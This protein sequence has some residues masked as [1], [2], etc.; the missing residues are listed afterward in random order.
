M[1]PGGFPTPVQEIRGMVSETSRPRLRFGVD[2]TVAPNRSVFFLQST[3]LRQTSSGPSLAG[4]CAPREGDFA[5]DHLPPNPTLASPSTPVILVH[6]RHPLP[7]R[8]H[9]PP[10]FPLAVTELLAVESQGRAPGKPFPG[11]ITPLPTQIASPSTPCIPFPPAPPPAAGDRVVS[12][13]G[14]P[15]RGGGGG[16]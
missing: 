10:S 15:F 8:P 7:L 12:P 6:P 2:G 14:R 4:D 1:G 5:K 3:E 16:D 13:R 9:S 11:R